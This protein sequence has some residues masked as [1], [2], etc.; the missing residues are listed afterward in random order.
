MIKIFRVIALI[1]GVSTVLLFLVAMPLKYFGD[2]PHLV[3]PVGQAHGVLWILYTLAIPICLLGRGFTVLEL[4]R[5][6]L[7]GL[8]PLG[9]FL[10]DGLIRRGAKRNRPATS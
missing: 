6:F 2:W 4:L 3:P 10:N 9:T 1:E 8:I 7:A 5:T